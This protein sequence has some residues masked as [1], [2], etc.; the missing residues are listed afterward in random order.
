MRK[1]PRTRILTTRVLH[2]VVVGRAIRKIRTEKRRIGRDWWTVLITFGEKIGIKN[3]IVTVQIHTTR[4]QFLKISLMDTGGT[5]LLL[6]VGKY[7]YHGCYAPNDRRRIFG[8]N[9]RSCSDNAGSHLFV[10]LSQTVIN[11]R[12]ENEKLN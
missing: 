8:Y 7:T 11:K 3:A 5:S 2:R 6:V 4:E 1:G 9:V 12:T 10:C